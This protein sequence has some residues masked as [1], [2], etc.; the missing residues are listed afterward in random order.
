MNTIYQQALN[1]FRKVNGTLLLFLVLFLDVKL[2]VKLIALVLFLVLAIRKEWLRKFLQ[3]HY[4]WFYGGM[5]LLC[6][7]SIA[8]NVPS[9]S[10]NYFITV[11][12]GIG[13]WGMCL[14]AAYLVYYYVQTTGKERLHNTITLFF[15]LNAIFTFIQ[16]AL[17]MWD[18]GD[19]NPYAYQGMNQKYFIS[20]GDLLRGL[21]FDVSTTNATLNAFAVLYFLD[22][23]KM[24]ALVC[25]MAALLLTASNYTT[26]LLLVILLSL[27]V[28]RSDR[29][30]KSMIILCG[31]MLVIFLARI[32]PQNQRY[33]KYIYQKLSHSRIDTLPPDLG[34]P[35]LSSL[36]DSI[37]SQE[38][39]RKK[40]AMLYLDSV[41]KANIAP[42]HADINNVKETGGPDLAVSK[43]ALPKPNIH[44]APYQRL[45]D[46]TEQQR[47]MIEY[48][49][50][51]IPAFDTGTQQ[52]V[53]PLP[54]KLLAYRQ[55]I[56]YLRNHPRYLATGM[57]PGQFSS[58]LAFRATGMQLSGGY[59]ESWVYINEG[60][61]DNH[62]NLYLS[63]F[64]K[65]MEVHSLANS[66]DSV[67]D[68]LIAEYGLLGLLAFLLLYCW[69]FIKKANPRSYALPFLLMMSAVLLAGYWFEQLSI[70]IIFELMMLMQ[71]KQNSE[72][73][74][75]I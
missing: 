71:Q 27:F 31:C 52:A 60:F 61:R 39:Q 46:T 42:V 67:Y 33:L 10:T 22:R 54:G 47:Q 51:N 73:T 59:P 49:L 1:Y 44:T 18:A 38:D 4:A 64:S 9:F 57:G 63:Y 2:L 34:K 62:L 25:C 15:I 72:M 29:T 17:I 50:V 16:L 48:A 20:T 23:R 56:H 65:D 26:V 8:I 36:P 35:P 41:H 19:I 58:K 53:Q 45:R 21:S 68:Q 55:T 74:D 13:G 12:A 6:L 69:Y 66:P 32:S 3:Q 11:L 14:G 40:F 70:F 37:L 5:I 75:S 7:V 28:F 30:Q 43:P 24:G